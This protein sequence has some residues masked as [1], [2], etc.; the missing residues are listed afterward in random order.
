MTRLLLFSLLVLSTY[1]VQAQNPLQRLPGAGLLGG[2][3]IGGGGGGGGPF[4][5]TLLHRTGLEDSITIAFRYLDTS[6][7]YYLDSTVNDFSKKWHLPWTHIFLGNTGSASRSLLFSPNM[8]PGWDDGF[9]AYDAYIPKVEE[10]K[11]YYSTRP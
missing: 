2:N 9:H 10:T 8:K 5:D 1:A 6:R 11:F 3:R 7:F 4:K